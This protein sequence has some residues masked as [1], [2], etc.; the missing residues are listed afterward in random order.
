MFGGTISVYAEN[1]TKYAST[2]YGKNK[3]YFKAKPCGTY[4]KQCN[5]RDE[6]GCCQLKAPVISTLPQSILNTAT[7]RIFQ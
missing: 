6:D 7:P 3:N 1:R 5:L 4:S 2:L